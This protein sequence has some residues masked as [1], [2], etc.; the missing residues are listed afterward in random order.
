MNLVTSLADVVGP[1]G[2]PPL[3][4]TTVCVWAIVVAAVVAGCAL[5]IRAIAKRR[6]GLRHDDRS[7]RTSPEP[8]PL[9]S[10]SEEE[11]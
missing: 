2:G 9:R 5:V 8:E 3:S 11:P 1:A 4:A 7:A 6:H 10:D